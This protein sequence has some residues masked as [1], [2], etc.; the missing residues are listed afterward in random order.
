MVDRTDLTCTI[1]LG[2]ATTGHTDLSKLS[3]IPR[4]ETTHLSSSLID[5]DKHW[6]NDNAHHWM[7]KDHPS[8][9]NFTFELRWEDEAWVTDTPLLDIAW[10]HVEQ[11]QRQRWTLGTVILPAEFQ[12]SPS[13]IEVQASRRATLID[14]HSAHVDILIEGVAPGTFVKVTEYIPPHCTCE[15]LSA[16]QASLRKEENAQIFLWFQAPK[17][18]PLTPSYRIQCASNVQN[19]AFGGEIEVAFGTQTKTSDIATVEWA[20]SP[21]ASNEN[22]GLNLSP[23]SES[24]VTSGAQLPGIQRDTPPA[25]GLAYAVQ[26]LA[27]HRDLTAEELATELGYTGSHTIYKHEGWHKYLTPEVTT[28]QEAHDV[29]SKVWT[30]TTATDA[31]VTA[32]LEGTRISLQ[33]ALLLSN[34][35]WIP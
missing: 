3:L 1:E 2:L 35:T 24:V 19:A 22:M 14:A 29:R 28:Y 30:S 11:G 33:E 23:D 32:S 18:E 7:W 20:E 26:L 17:G 13:P 25:H 4:N 5:C 15:V 27:N 10:E 31:F 12:P 6:V 8:L 16:S 9:L 21:S 34:Q